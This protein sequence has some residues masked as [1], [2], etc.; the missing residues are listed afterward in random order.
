M[1]D[2]TVSE[3]S[4]NGRATLFT[5]PS[6]P[7]GGGTISSGGGMLSVGSSDGAAGWT[8][9]LPLP[10][11][12][13]LTPGIT[14]SYSSG[15]GNSAF[16]A[17]WD[18][19]P[20][21]IFRMTRFGIPRYSESDRLVGP[22]GEEILRD[23]SNVRRE[24]ALPYS[25]KQTSV[26]LATPWVSRSG[27]R[28]ERLEHWITE[29][30]QN[31]PGFWLQWHADGSITLYGW[32]AAARLSDPANAT[33]VAGWFAE[34]TV[35]ATGGHLVYRYR[36]ENDDHCSTEERAAHPQV[37]NRY[38]DAVYAM[39]MTPSQSFL[40]PD[41][42]FQESDFLSFMQFDYG[43]RKV[44]INCSP[45]AEAT[46]QWLVRKDCTS[47]WRYGFNVRT[48]RLCHDV[49]LWQ[50]TAVMAGGD[51]ATPSL[52]SRIHLTYENSGVVSLLTA[53]QQIA[54][55]EDGTP[56]S[57]PPVE[58]A[59]NQPGSTTPEWE[60]VKTLD[61]FSP[62]QWQMADLYG[63][64]MPGLLYQD[65]G[66]WWYRAPV[67]LSGNVPDDVT[68]ENAKLLPFSPGLRAGLL[69]DLDGDGRPEWLATGV[70]LNGSF[71]LSPDGGWS[72]FIPLDA[73][74]AELL[75][76]DAL[77]ADL[78][79]G[80][81]QDVV[82]V[83]PRSVRLY[84]SALKAGW[85]AAETGIYAGR[86]VLPVADGEHHFVAFTDPVGSG[87]QH[88]VQITGEGVT[89]WP[90]LGYGCFAE[91]INIPGFNVKDFSAS[92]VFLG[93]TDGSGT[94]DILYVE[95]DR[96]RIFISQCGNRF[97]E[98]A[99]VLAP[100]GVRL[101]NT[102][103]LQ[104][105]DARGYGTA[106]LMLTVP[107][108]HPR[109]WLYRFND[110]RPW[111][112]KEVCTNTGSRMLFDYRSSAQSWLD[113]K[114]A[115][116]AVGKQAVSHLPFPVHTLSK[117]TIVDDISGLVTGSEMRYMR[118]IWDGR[119]REFRGFTHLIQRDTLSEVSDVAVVRSTPSE[120]HTWFLCGIEHHDAELEGYST[121]AEVNFPVRP[122]R[123]T[124][125]VQGGMDELYEPGPDVRRWLMRALKGV[126]LRIEL[127]GLDDSKLA[128]V[129]YSITRHRWQIRAYD[130]KNESHPA[131]LVTSIETLTITTERIMEDPVV[132]Q[133]VLVAQDVFGSPLQNVDIRYHRLPPVTPSPYPNTLPDGLES[134][135]RDPQ[136]DHVWLT[137][138]R[139]NIANVHKDGDHLTGLVSAI[140][141]DVMRL[142]AADVPPGGFSVESLQGELSPLVD[143]SNA[144]LSSHVRTQWCDTSG[145]LTDFPVRPPLVAYTETAMLD[146][147]SLAPF[148]ELLPAEELRSLLDKGG[149]HTVTLPQDGKIV[150]AGRHNFSRH[151]GVAGFFNLTAIRDSEL[152]GEMQLTWD[153]HYLNVT[154]VEDAA[155][156]RTSFDY[157]WRFSLPI[158][159]TD[160]NDNVHET[161]LDAQGRAVQSR[162]YGTE[163]GVMTGYCS[164]RTF[165]VPDTMEE[166]LA[167]KNGSV[168]VSTAH[169]IITDSWMP[170]ARDDKGN[171]MD[172]RIGEL[173]LRRWMAASGQQVDTGA[174]RVP[175]HIISL[176][177]DRYDGDNEQQVRL[178]VTFSDG[179]GRSLQTSVLNPPG[180]AFMRTQDGRLMSDVDGKAVVTSTNLRWAVTGRTEFD[181]KGQPVRTWLPF[182]LDDWRPV[183]KD[184][185]LAG[186]YAD[187]YVYDA[188]GRVYLVITAAG[189]ER[190]TQY[191]PWFT[192]SED[193]NDTAHEV[194]ARLGT[195]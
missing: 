12:R 5:P 127:Y 187:T 43:E 15:G 186:I 34:E 171:L 14:L 146:A 68:W 178:T 112:L 85:L 190:R 183:H 121:G 189:W 170:F 76:P 111:L 30:K 73:M 143:L 89:Y 74:P 22:S 88:L 191:F 131:A 106:E 78:T 117:V 3:S 194:L 10:S 36:L 126:P 99:P 82:M 154:A 23:S 7:K 116:K 157:D 169:R 80:G 26:W 31:D 17:G 156:L 40:I 174:G 155:G 152:T 28:A 95:H 145:N 62:L 69:T 195:K 120:T 181:N 54:Y 188:M 83:G 150:H 47:F 44:D 132:A 124:K 32:S 92:R 103:L 101:D 129:P 8:L 86:G 163:N 66:A 58:F 133:S 122:S 115:L 176:Q 125:A 107:Y 51:D 61:G 55:E 75:H 49:L 113:E 192:V 77:L 24:T 185:R 52:I 161:M 65:S 70:S 48:R 53:A 162:F 20:P 168:P 2:V 98:S 134:A 35:S 71:T 63:E 37:A 21:A 109:T 93:D 160:P 193:E 38:L 136:Q 42:A 130:T 11:G 64:G 182:F 79:G 148:R 140:R 87:Q 119:E 108:V 175:P 27:G 128:S 33:R 184:E 144:T 6:L 123:I 173:A 166:M 151:A 16:G 139:Q 91:P 9:P 110:T 147:A 165:E 105:T 138:T 46:G 94:T 153:K 135:S 102:C 172:G 60:A 81:L 45:P 41:G 142:A 19:S 59:F 97:V 50:R 141:S 18:C 57:L 25:E 179:G 84:A 29:S 39:N 177:T 118:G 13:G 1:S 72:G 67:R 96:I 164:G 149:Y 137:L 90:S 159:I 167:L 4:E 180:E 114:A 56:I 104:V 158:R 100:E